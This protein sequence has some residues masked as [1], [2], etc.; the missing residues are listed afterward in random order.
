MKVNIKQILRDLL[1]VLTAGKKSKIHSVFVLLTHPL[2]VYNALR[3]KEIYI[4]H[5]DVVITTVCTL[6]C[7]GCGALIE[8]YNPPKHY[9]YQAIIK[10]LNNLLWRGGHI[11]RIHILGGEPLCYPYLYEILCYLKNQK[12]VNEVGIT[13]NGTLILKDS[14]VIDILCDPKF[15][16]EFSNY[17]NSV[18]KKMPE[19][20]H[21]LMERGIKYIIRETGSSWIDFGNFECRNRDKSELNNMYAHCGL[22]FTNS[23]IEGKLYHC[24]WG[25]HGA[26]LGLIPVGEKDYVDLSIAT[27]SLRKD[28]FHFLY[29]NDSSIEACNYCDATEHPRY[30][31]AGV[32]PC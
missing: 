13:T 16:I 28:L 26:N 5:V 25:A 3:G 11:N 29:S 20:I 14:R 21:I 10:S 30:I 2:K 7:K 9:D 31:K 12:N 22:R 24:S 1:H 8:Y 27:N 19:M 15:S 6:K 4:K 18:S 32:Q 17:G 23:I